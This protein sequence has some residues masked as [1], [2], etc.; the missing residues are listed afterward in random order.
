MVHQLDRNLLVMCPP[1]SG[2]GK[3]RCKTCHGT[4]YVIKKKRMTEI[5]SGAPTENLAVCGDCRGMRETDCKL[6]EGHKEVEH[7]V[8]TQFFNKREAEKARIK[9]KDR[10]NRVLVLSLGFAIM[11]L[12]NYC[13]LN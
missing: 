5:H 10:I 8:A 11:I 4:G 12:I 2:S 13:I 7:E 1:C 6:C 3:S 9:K